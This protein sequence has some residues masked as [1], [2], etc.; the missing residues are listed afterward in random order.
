M[1]KMIGN[2]RKYYK[3]AIVSAWKEM[4]YIFIFG[5]VLIASFLSN[6]ISGV[7]DLDGIVLFIIWFSSCAAT[8]IITATIV[9]IMNIIFD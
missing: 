7:Y 3:L 9:P 1:N 2:V 8:T 6:G 4:W 5:G